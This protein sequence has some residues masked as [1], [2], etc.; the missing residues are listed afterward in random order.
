VIKNLEADTKYFVR[1]VIITN[2]G[3]LREG[4]HLKFKEFTTNCQDISLD[5]IDIKSTNTSAFVSLK[6]PIQNPV[7]KLAKYHIYLEVTGNRGFFYNTTSVYFVGLNSFTPYTI[8]F[9]RDIQQHQKN[10]K[11]TFQTGEGVPQ[12]V[13]NLRVAN[14]SSSTIYIKWEKPSSINGVFRHYIVKYRVSG[15]G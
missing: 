11:K 7:C 4:S 6:T 2:N 9:Q 5:N 15:L 14:K 10:Q 1:S 8:I 12:Q 3:N 13:L